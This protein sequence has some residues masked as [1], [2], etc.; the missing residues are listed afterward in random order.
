[1][2]RSFN[3]ELGFGSE[4]GRAGAD[5]PKSALS[6]TSIDHLD[7]VAD[8]IKELRQMAEQQKAPA[9]AEILDLAFRQAHREIEQARGQRRR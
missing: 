2:N 4:L 7:Y 8:M 5:A 9:L 1:M 6:A 3:S